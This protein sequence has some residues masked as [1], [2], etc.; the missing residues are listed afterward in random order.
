MP[1]AGMLVDRIGAGRI[2]MVG[3]I[4]IT[5][6]M[7]MFAG[8]DATTSYWYLMA[9]LF[10]MGMGTGATMMPVMTAALQTLKNHQI[11]RGSTLMNIAQQVAA[12]I[13]TAVFTVVL[14]SN[15]RTSRSPSRRSPPGSIRR[16]R[17]SSDRPRS[18]VVWSRPRTPSAAPS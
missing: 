10:I 3:I 11:A 15:L 8:L 9:A 16:S 4:V 1:V 14:T 5:A 18:P 2:I 7:G 6:G 12:S 17:A 13:G